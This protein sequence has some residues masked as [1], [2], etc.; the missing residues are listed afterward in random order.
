MPESSTAPQ[1]VIGKAIQDIT[2]ARLGRGFLPLAILGVGG[3]GQLVT[4]G[5][6]SPDGL[7]LVI[8]AVAAGGT[9][10]AY[11]LRIVQRAFGRENKVWMKAAM[12]G[13]LVPPLFA[14]YVFGW[15][16]LRGFVRGEGGSGIVL[17]ILFSAMGVWVLLTW[18]RVVEVERLARVM[19]LNMDQEGGPA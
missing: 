2:A 17:A 16:G 19:A 3:I 14:L 8:G 1:Q 9:M 7:K 4:G 11:G 18:M 15:R 6:G 13:S 12:L 10:L 5:V